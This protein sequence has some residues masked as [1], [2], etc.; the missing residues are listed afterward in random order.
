MK[1]MTRKRAQLI[2]YSLSEA[3]EQGRTMR[4]AV[5]HA[6][7][8]D[9]IPSAW[10]QCRAAFVMRRLLDSLNGGRYEGLPDYV[11]YEHAH[12]P[13]RYRVTAHRNP[14]RRFRR[15]ASPTLA[16]VLERMSRP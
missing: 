13:P 3:I 7:E 1:R 8:Y 10:A 16:W 5:E 14:C 4:W 9:P 12:R 6:R 2:L 15:Y 11:R